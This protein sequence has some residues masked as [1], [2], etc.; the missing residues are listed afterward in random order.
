MR[1]GDKVRIKLQLRRYDRR[2]RGNRI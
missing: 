2:R 1:D